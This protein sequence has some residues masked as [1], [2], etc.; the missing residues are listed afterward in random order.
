MNSHYIPSWLQCIEYEALTYRNGVI[1]RKLR[2]SH[3]N[4]DHVTYYRNGRVSKQR[5]HYSRNLF[6]EDRFYESG[7]PKSI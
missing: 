7:R 6:L 3:G 1:Q 4:L 2:K 5:I